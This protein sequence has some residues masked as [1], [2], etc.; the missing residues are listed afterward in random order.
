MT[1]LAQARP[2]KKTYQLLRPILQPFSTI[3]G[4]SSYSPNLKKRMPLASRVTGISTRTLMPK[5]VTR[6][7]I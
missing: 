4:S 5:K 2:V 6:S 1:S 7:L 3:S